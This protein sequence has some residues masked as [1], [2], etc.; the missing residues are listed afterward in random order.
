MPIMDSG[1]I[2]KNHR[3]HL[4]LL[5]SGLWLGQIVSLG[6]RKPVTEDSLTD[7]VTRVPG[8]YPSEAEA[9]QAASKYIDHLE[10][11]E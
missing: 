2:Y 7:T 11:I 8:E 3:I 5:K 9:L 6:G 4:S 1:V 10:G